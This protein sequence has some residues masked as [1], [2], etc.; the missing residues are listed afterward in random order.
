MCHSKELEPL[1]QSLRNNLWK[2]VNRKSIQGFPFMEYLMDILINRHKKIT[3]T[4]TNFLKM[5]RD[6]LKDEYAMVL[7]YVQSNIMNGDLIQLDRFIRNRINGNI[8]EILDDFIEK[9][10]EN[11]KIY[12]HN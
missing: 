2:M 12:Q 10:E 8:T 6:M 1:R 5:Y 11:K 9:Y 7:D 3:I 4:S